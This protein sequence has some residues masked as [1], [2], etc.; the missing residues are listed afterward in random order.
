[1]MGRSANVRKGEAPVPWLPVYA[2]CSQ[3]RPGQER[4]PRLNWSHRWLY[5]FRQRQGDLG[6]NIIVSPK[7]G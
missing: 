5:N 2:I 3:G 7:E 4:H 1:M 6:A